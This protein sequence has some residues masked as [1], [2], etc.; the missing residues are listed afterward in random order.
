[1]DIITLIH[2]IDDMYNRKVLVNELIKT[3][4]TEREAQQAENVRNYIRN[5]STLLEPG[6]ELIEIKADGNCEFRA[7]AKIIYNNDDDNT[8]HKVRREIIQY[9]I[10]KVFGGEWYNKYSE[11]FN[12]FIIKEKNIKDIGL[13]DNHVTVNDV[14]DKWLNSYIP[15][16]ETLF[17]FDFIKKFNSINEKILGIICTYMKG[18]PEIND[19]I[20][21][22]NENDGNIMIDS[23]REYFNKSELKK[24]YNIDLNKIKSNKDVRSFVDIID[25]QINN[26]EDID[27]IIDQENEN[28]YD[29]IESEYKNKTLDI[30]KGKVEKIYD[31]DSDLIDKQYYKNLNKYIK[32]EIIGSLEASLISTKDFPPTWGDG[33]L[34]PFTASE[35]YEITLCLHQVT[36]DKKIEYYKL[37]K[38]EISDILLINNPND[39]IPRKLLFHDFT[40]RG[41]FDVILNKN[42]KALNKEGIVKLKME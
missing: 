5:E 23:Y 17:D 37:T 41:H 38:C 21:K 35:L 24:K 18:L 20:P 22:I 26:N 32:Q 15:T 27:S 36:Y 11:L 10:K 7:L 19:L 14:D 12:D 3:K 39:S 25:Q 42:H 16:F 30:K 40:I 9:M 1:M 6:E 4:I 31:E 8:T 13:D 33:S 34:I 28:T 2:C 29:D